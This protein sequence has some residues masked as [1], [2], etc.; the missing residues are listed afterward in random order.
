MSSS[1][2]PRLI[3]HWLR[4]HP[5]AMAAAISHLN[6]MHCCMMTRRGQSVFVVMAIALPGSL[7]LFLSAGGPVFVMQ[8]ALGHAGIVIVASALYAALPISGHR[9]NAETARAT[10]WLI[11]TPRMS[12]QSSSVTPLMIILLPLWPLAVGVA[13]ALLLSLDSKVAVG[14]S[15]Q[16]IALITIG[17]I[18][19]ASCGWWLSRRATTRWM[20]VSRHTPLMKIATHPMPSNAALSEWPIVQALASGRSE[21]ARLLLGTAILTVP[22]G[23]GVIGLLITLVTWVV[24]SY[25]VALLIAIP[26]VARSASRWLRCTPI[27]FWAFA[28]P[29]ARRALLHQLLGTLIAIGVMMT[30]GASPLTALY[31]GTLW[32][33]LVVLTGALSLA[34]CYRAHSPTVKLTLSVVAAALAEERNHGLGI[35]LA[36]FLTALNLRLGASHERS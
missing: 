33:T 23:T 19:G 22:G 4:S 20:E 31:C 32:L 27:T 1:S 5:S 21:N 24:G 18:A 29:L 28:W 15:L 25:L 3:P 12:R 16:L 36:L 26:I 6:R 13:C 35:S 14:Q 2:I 8:C 7:A 34:D 11:A 10:S 30:I 9:R 17:S